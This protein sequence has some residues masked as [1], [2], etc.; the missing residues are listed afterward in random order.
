MRHSYEVGGVTFTT[1]MVWA[2]VFPFVALQFYEG[3]DEEEKEA[4]KLFLVGSLCL[5]LL[6]TIAFFCTI[7]LNYLNTFIGS[8]SGP[9][10]TCELF[11]TS[12]E[13]SA[14]FRAAFKNRPSYTKHVHEEVKVWVTANID[15]WHE[16]RPSWFKIELIPDDFLPD[17]VLAAERGHNRKRSTVSI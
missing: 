1:S 17:T 10:Y 3:S 5:C 14:K 16:D 15:R 11:S 8:K 7:D 12:E 2:Q 4:L 9:Q 13:E 6:L